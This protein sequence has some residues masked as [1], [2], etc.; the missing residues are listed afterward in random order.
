M[1]RSL[2]VFYTDEMERLA[3]QPVADH[4]RERGIDVKQSTD[5]SE[6]C[7][8]G[9][10]C[11]HVS[12]DQEWPNAD[13]SAIMFHGMDQ[14]WYKLWVDEP[15]DLFDVGLVP[16]QSM[17]ERWHS[18][19]YMPRARPTHGVYEVG[20]PKS[21]GVFTDAFDETVAEFA[22]QFDFSHDLSLLYA[23]TSEINGKLT[24]FVKAAEDLDTNLL[25]KHA[26][27]EGADQLQNNQEMYDLHGG[28]P[29]VH[30][31]DPEV[32]IIKPLALA[33]VLVSDSSS[34]Q[35]EA[36]L[37][38]TPVIAVM[39]WQIQKKNDEQSK[40]PRKPNKFEFV[41]RT[42]QTDLKRI[43]QHLL[44][45]LDNERDRIR[46][47]RDYH[48]SHQGS[49]A[50]VTLDVIEALVD[51]KTPQI[52]PVEPLPIDRKRVCCNRAVK[53]STNTAG[54]ILPNSIV[55]RLEQSSRI[56]AVLDSA[57]RK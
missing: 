9:L 46:M 5:L 23:P 33:D 53:W 40:Y 7:E 32:D 12:P 51:E 8:V 47:Y 14:G 17:A 20:W 35:F 49:G 13:F 50:D 11:D 30:I 15:W 54:D 18:Y 44:S 43:L 6:P 34:V 27:Y 3:V 57:Y 2:T 29:D 21:D 24:S 52:T 48:F 45:E 26:P 4:A 22:E 56:D 38:D 36:L 39:D 41:H 16:G 55:K 10:Y 37:L 28:H 25:V 19:S 42:T 1:N 31:V